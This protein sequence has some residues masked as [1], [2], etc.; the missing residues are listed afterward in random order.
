MTSEADLDAA[1]KGL[2]ILSEHSELYA[3]FAKLGCVSSLVTLLSHENTDIAID[4]IEVL[5]ELIDE[6]VEADEAQWRALVDAMLDADVVELL[7]Q[8]LA[9]MDEEAESD[10]AGVYHV[11]GVIENLCSQQSVA[12]NMGDQNEGLLKW[13]LARIQR[14]ERRVGQNM[15]YAAEILAILLQSSPKTRRRFVDMGGLDS[16]LEIL[17]AYRKKDPEKDS[18]EEEYAENLFDCLVCLMDEPKGKEKFVEAEG[19]ELC[20]IMLREG[21]MSKPRALRV[22][23]HAMA[24]SAGRGVCEQ[25][26]E[27][28]GLRS[29]FGMFMKRQEREAVEHLLGIF[30]SLLRLLP[31]RSAPRVR[32]LAK[33]VENDYEKV[34]KLVEL[35]RKYTETMTNVEEAIKAEAQP[36]GAKEREVKADEWLSRRL[37][38]GLF[39][40]QTVDIVLSW[41][42]A[43]DGGARSRVERLLS[44]Q[45]KSL[46]NLKQSLQ[47]QLDGM[48]AGQST[49]QAEVKDMLGALLN[50]L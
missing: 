14:K 50:C 8:N 25:V 45:D 6:D 16:M 31:G 24:G 1:I 19:V 38:A 47:E 9:R 12:E 41:L 37:D 44:D 26:V 11:L 30:S 33:F 39:S 43:E 36:L 13:L 35:R 27:A 4:A 17:S 40:L 42:V 48:K 22:L 23:D 15:Q 29:I 49:E 32:T 46:E 28:A 7:T 34:G 3:E 5:G 20:L 2:S 10:R 18:D 21:K